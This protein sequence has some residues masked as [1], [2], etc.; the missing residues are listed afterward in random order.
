MVSFQIL[1][2]SLQ[3]YNI[4]NILEHFRLPF[5]R[6]VNVL[7]GQEYPYRKCVCMVLNI[8]EAVKIYRNFQDFQTYQVCWL[9]KNYQDFEDFNYQDL[10]KNMFEIIRMFSHILIFCEFSDPVSLL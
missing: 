6:Y 1:R 8:Y 2:G 10:K 4:C 7:P 3:M 9:F 5:I